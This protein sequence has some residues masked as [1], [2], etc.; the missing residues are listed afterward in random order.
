[1]ARGHIACSLILLSSAFLAAQ[2]QPA[3]SSDAHAVP[4]IDADAGSCSLELTVT[5]DGKPVYA[6]AIKVH[7]AYG[8]GGFHKLDLQ[9]STNVDGK[10]RFAGLPAKVRRPPLQFHASKDDL[11]GLVKYDPAAECKSQQEIALKKSPEG[12]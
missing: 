1:M 7:I 3:A 2:S 11:S 12:K 9:A 10:V 5:A 8:F 4:V 6:A